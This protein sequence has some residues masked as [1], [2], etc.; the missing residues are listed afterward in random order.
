MDN[1]S[2]SWAA[3]IIIYAAGYATGAASLAILLGL[4]R[5]MRRARNVEEI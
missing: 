4:L 1:H 3:A 2:M 5:A